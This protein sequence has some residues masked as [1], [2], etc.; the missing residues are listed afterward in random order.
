MAMHKGMNSTI[1]IINVYL[2]L[3]LHRLFKTIR[4]MSW[5]LK[6]IKNE[7]YGNYCGDYS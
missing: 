7:I 4:K 5:S 1:E 6:Y 3:I 2:N